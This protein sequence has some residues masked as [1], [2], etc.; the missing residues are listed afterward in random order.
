MWFSPII[1]MTGD[2]VFEATA[3]LRAGLQDLGNPTGGAAGTA[4][5]V[6][7]CP[8]AF[9]IIYFFPSSTTSRRTG[10]IARSS[11]AREGRAE[12]GWAST[13]RTPR[14]WTTSPRYSFNNRA[15]WRLHETIKD[16]L[17]PNGILRAGKNGVWP[18]RLRRTNA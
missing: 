13:A 11:T 17:D 9:V 15:L 5:L 1:P 10:A 16:A 7:L 18:R 14:S 6:V 8:R 2:A 3:C 4:D 12:H